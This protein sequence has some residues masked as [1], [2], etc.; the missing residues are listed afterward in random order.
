MKFSVQGCGVALVTPFNEQGAIDFDAMIKLVDHVVNGGV[1]YI[2]LF[3]T[4]GESPTVTLQEKQEALRLVSKHLN[5]K[6]PIVIGFGGNNT[7][8]LIEEMKLFNFEGASAILSV[9]PYYNKPNQDG[10][11]MHYKTISDNAPLPVILY[12]VPGRTVVNM[13]PST[14]IR[15]ANAC[16]N[17]IAIKEAT[18][19][20]D[21]IMDLLHEK[22]EAFEVVAGDDALALPIISLGACGVIS[23]IA[24]AY[25]KEFSNMVH[26][27]MKGDMD[28]A[29]K[30]HYML[31]PIMHTL[32]KMGNPSGIKAVLH[33]KELIQHV[34]RL[35][36]HPVNDEKFSELLKV[37]ELTEKNCK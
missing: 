4:T 7:T 27:A 32:L 26:A 20:M 15:I 30:Y 31:L 16:P 14:S 36:V 5:G 21:Q 12:N 35:P 3:G 1:D 34:F 29:R 28:E 9:M 19:N 33:I 2:V 13:E 18:D 17:I 22:P 37:V 11:Y 6:V 23:V 24:N 10:I 8:K 25:P